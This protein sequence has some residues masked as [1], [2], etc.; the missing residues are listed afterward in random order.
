MLD[1]DLAEIYGV[2]TRRLNE[3]VKRNSQRFPEDFMFQLVR[4]FLRLRRMLEAHE[5]LARK[6]VAMEKK[7]DRNFK[8]V[9]EAIRRL[10]I[11]SKKPSEERI[12]FR[13]PP[14]RP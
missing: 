6:L 4:A 10:M 8:T 14:R 13:A 7:Y 1:S 3:Q 2:S 11:P 9:F 5:D 12:G